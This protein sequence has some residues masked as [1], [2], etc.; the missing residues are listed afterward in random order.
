MTGTASLAGTV[1]L[2]PA[3][4]PAG[5][6]LIET[7]GEPAGFFSH[8]DAPGA[9]SPW[10]VAYGP[11]GATAVSGGALPVFVAIAGS[12]Q[13]GG[14]LTCGF[15]SALEP[16]GTTTYRWLAPY[17]G[18][19]SVAPAIKQ[20][21]LTAFPGTV[22][23][24]LAAELGNKQVP[25]VTVP[26]TAVGRRVGCEINVWTPAGGA[27]GPVH[28]EGRSQPL[29]IGGPF[30][31]TRGPL[32]LGRPIPG[33]RL[34]CS[35]GSWEGTPSSYSYAWFSRRR[36]E[37]SAVFDVSGK[38]SYTVAPD[39]EGSLMCVV[40]AHYGA[41][42]VPAEAFVEV[43]ARPQPT[44]CPRRPVALVSVRRSARAVLLFGAAVQRDFG[45]RAYAFRRAGGGRWQRVA[46]GRVNGSGYFELS[47]ALSR[48]AP[49]RGS[50]RVEVGR[51]SSVAV[52]L[53]GVLQIAS[54]RSR[55]AESQ[56]TLRLARAGVL[57]VTRL[58]ECRP[59]SAVATATLPA[60]GQ[61]H[62]QLPGGSE[63]VAYL[64]RA[65][66]GGRTYSTELVVPARRRPVKL[67]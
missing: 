27:A 33:S 34:T 25:A 65:R 12:P 36:T 61:L 4:P 67:L 32:I 66:V 50:Y 43:P 63:P 46:S 60:G 57:T 47:L 29:A 14:T 26:G 62:V 51:T 10:T 6:P 20:P 3:A 23:A 30:R 5:F 54:D 21:G 42:A 41:V 8:V 16:R 15:G 17:P 19:E 35:P 59:S 28:T 48:G 49:A 9:G 37:E 53:P 31:F 18:P 1:S 56:V 55:P 52:G 7:A 58:D 13:P 64:A 11:G 22:E 38:S 24:Q 40:T 39:L 45:E 44:L 2:E